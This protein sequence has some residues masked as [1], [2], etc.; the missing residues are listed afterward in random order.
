MKKI[1]TVQVFGNEVFKEQK[2]TIGV[3]LGDRWS[4]YCVLEEAGQII[5]EQKVPT[6]P[7]AMKQTFSRIPQSRMALETGTHS[8]WVSRLLTELGHEVIVAHAQKVQLITKSN[9]KDDPHDARTLA[10][11]ARIDPE[12]LGPIRHRSVQAQIHL[13]VIR[14]RAELVSARTALVNAARGLVKSYGQR[15]PKCGTQQVSRELA[16]ALSTE[17]RDVLEPLLKEIESLN[18]RIKEYDERMEKI[19]K[20]VYPEV[21]LLKQVKGVGTQI[22]LTYVLTIEDP[23]R[24]VKSLPQKRGKRGRLSGSSTYGNENTPLAPSE[25]RSQ[26]SADGRMATG[27]GLA[28]WEQTHGKK[29]AKCALPST[30]LLMEGVGLTSAGLCEIIRPR[31][32]EVQHE[33]PN[34]NMGGC[35]LSRCELVGGL[36]LICKQGPSD[37][38]DCFHSYPLNLPR[39]D[40]RLALS[41]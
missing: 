28:E 7:E 27:A 26:K 17:L 41:R 4:F 13:T 34:R 31:Q 24:F 30:G 37:R 40:C 25:Y 33:I 32:R 8:P 12:L 22:A 11:L 15:L 5:L 16:A 23:H 20:E 10:R 19:A 18:E 38:T 9:R 14:A 29:K 39:C 3:D 36:F 21:S 35:G 6:T 2:L 1:S